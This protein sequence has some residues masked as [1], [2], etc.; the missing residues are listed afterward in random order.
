VKPYEDEVVTVAAQVLG[1]RKAIERFE[2]AAAQPEDPIE[3]YLPLFE[4]LNWIVAL[5][6]RIGAI[7]VPEGKKLGPAWR[8]R[9]SEGNVIVGLDWVRNVVHHQWADALQ[10]DPVGHGVYPSPDLYPSPNLYPRHEFAWVWRA[11]ADLPERKARRRGRGQGVD[12]GRSAYETHL[13]GRPAADTL[14]ESLRAC[15][16]V[17]GLLEPRRLAPTITG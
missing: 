17:V 7:C 3:A 4:A 2:V 8:G 13:E 16:W 6:N 11:V 14:R 5:D 10:L 1:L 15:E 9:V 12:P